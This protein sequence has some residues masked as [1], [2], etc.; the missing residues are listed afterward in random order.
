MSQAPNP[1]IKRMDYLEGRWQDEHE[2]EDFKEYIANIKTVLP[3]GA[4]FVSLTKK[5][6]KLIYVHNGQRNVVTVTAAGINHDI[7]EVN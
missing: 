7:Y 3:E 4:V 2:Y 1:V 6:F 5:P